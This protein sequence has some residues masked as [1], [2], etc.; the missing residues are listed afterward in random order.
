MSMLLQTD[1]LT[2]AH[3]WPGSRWQEAG[4]GTFGLE[5]LQWRAEVAAMTR[6]HAPPNPVVDRFIELLLARVQAA[7]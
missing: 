4:I 5:G 7:R 2:V 6:T 1:L 3:E